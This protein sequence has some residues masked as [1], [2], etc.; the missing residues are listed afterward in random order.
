MLWKVLTILLTICLL[1]Y[2]LSRIADKIYIPECKLKQCSTYGT[3]IL[4]NS[5]DKS[6][7]SHQIIKVI[8]MLS[9]VP[10][11]C[12]G[13]IPTT[14]RI[15]HWLLAVVL[16][17]NKVV[18][19]NTSS[20]VFI[21]AYNGRINEKRKLINYNDYIGIIKHVYTIDNTITLSTFLNKYIAYF[22]NKYKRYTLFGHDNCQHIVSDCLKYIFGID[23]NETKCEEYDLGILKEIYKTSKHAT[24][25]KNIIP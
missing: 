11:A 22:K 19:V 2:C 8:K 20:K 4:D 16:D 12:R 3:I 9:P 23:D 21:T 14:N 13:I 15:S 10:Y 1:V 24:N 18:V 25:F 17:N 5:F 6:L 7:L